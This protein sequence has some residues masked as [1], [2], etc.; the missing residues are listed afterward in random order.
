MTQARVIEL[1]AVVSPL[2]L[3]WG[4]DGSLIILIPPLRV[5]NSVQ[6]PRKRNTATRPVS[7][8]HNSTP[9][10]DIYSNGIRTRSITSSAFVYPTADQFTAK[11]CRAVYPVCLMYIH[12]YEWKCVSSSR[13]KWIRGGGCSLPH[14]FTLLHC[15]SC[16]SF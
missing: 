11:P 6:L 2:V 3:R 12:I 7:T 8:I 13:T 4:T 16:P 5:I 15:Q 9:G 1:L 14:P 10:V